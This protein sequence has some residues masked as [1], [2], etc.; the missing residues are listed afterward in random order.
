MF[1]GEPV[2]SEPNLQYSHWIEYKMRFEDIKLHPREKLMELCERLGIAWSDTMLKTT[3]GNRPTVE[4]GSI[5]FDLKAVFNKYED[6]L[7]EFDRFRIS[8]AGSPY[9]KGYGYSYYNCLKFSRKELQELFL[10]PLLVDEKNI[11]RNVDS[12]IKK[13]EWVRWQLWNVRKH[14]VLD[15]VLP[16]FARVEVGQT[17]KARMEE[18]QREQ[19]REQHRKRI[20]KAIKEAMG[21]I[22]KHDKLILYGIGDDCR[23][24]LK[25]IDESKKNCILYSDKK[26]EKES[27]TYMGRKVISP[28]ELCGAYSDYHILVTSSIYWSNIEEEFN[29]MGIAP[30]RVFYNRVGLDKEKV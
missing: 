19:K 4:H 30:F 18:Y 16:E 27:Y 13:R 14:M 20:E 25:E 3:A 21:Y 6:Y 7:S 12:S 17:G 26:A 28:K 22:G 23:C 29:S 10:K 9:Q 5:D 2:N 11:F 15:D 1:L 24:L 8:I